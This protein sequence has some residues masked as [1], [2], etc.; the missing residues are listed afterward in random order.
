MEKVINIAGKDVPL[1]STGSLPLRYKAQFKSDFFADLMKT[2]KAFN[3]KKPNEINFDYFDS[4]IFYKMIWCMAKT[5]N[6][7]IPDL[8]DF[9]D[10][11]DSFPFMDILPQVQDL[12]INSVT[13]IKRKN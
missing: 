4:E 12:L 13:A 10:S 6:P 7:D 5:A 1:K 11:F 3:P 8:L 2:Q 9:V